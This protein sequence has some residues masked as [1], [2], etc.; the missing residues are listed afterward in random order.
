MPS[1]MASLMKKHTCFLPGV[2]QLLNQVRYA[3]FVALF[4]ALNK[5]LGNGMWSSHP[6]FMVLGFGSLIL[7]TS[8]LV[9]LMYVNDV[10][11][12]GSLESNI[13]ETK[14][15]L[16]S[17]FTIKDKGYAKYFL[18]IEIAR[19]PYETYIHQRKYILDL[20]M[21]A[22]LLGAKPTITPLPKEHKFF[23]ESGYL[24]PDPAPFRHL[25]GRLLYLNFTRPDISYN[26]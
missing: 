2:I 5:P 14:T 19:H 10:L 25:V 20:L 18:G 26:V 7:I 22:G 8:F 4:M 13:L 12:A 3:F 6:S 24:L 23:I 15:F 9:L 11:I 16:H 17:C 21:D 1:S